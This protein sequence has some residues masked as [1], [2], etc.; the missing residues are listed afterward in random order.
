VTPERLLHEATELF[1]P[2]GGVDL[3]DKSCAV[4]VDMSQD[5]IRPLFVLAVA[6]L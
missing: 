4:D 6:R 2:F 1:C 5:G 3:R